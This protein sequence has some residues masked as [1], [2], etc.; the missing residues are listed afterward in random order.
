MNSRTLLFLS[1][2]VN[3]F[4][5]HSAQT[6]PYGL[7]GF[8]PTYRSG[9]DDLIGVRFRFKVTE[10]E[11]QTLR[12]IF[13]FQRLH[14]PGSQ[15][16]YV[17]ETNV[18]SGRVACYPDGGCTTWPL[19][20]TYTEH[21]S[22]LRLAIPDYAFYFR[23]QPGITTGIRSSD[24]VWYPIQTYHIDNIDSLYKSDAISQFNIDSIETLVTMERGDT[25]TDVSMFNR[26]DRPLLSGVYRK[27]TVHVEMPS[28]PIQVCTY[29][30]PDSGARYLT[31]NEA[32]NFASE[33]INGSGFFTVQYWDF[34][35]I[36]ES[37]PVWR[38]DTTFMSNSD[39]DGSG[40]DYG[41]RVVN[42]DGRDRVEFSNR[43]GNNYLPAN[44][45]FSTASWPSTSVD[46]HLS[47]PASP[48][49]D[50]NYPNPVNPSTTIR[51]QIPKG[52]HVSLKVF[53]V[54]GHVVADLVEKDQML[55]HYSVQW[56]PQ[57]STGTYFY[58]IQAPDLVETKRL[59]LIK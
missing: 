43:P 5:A 9:P 49:L 52:G 1:L 59:L 17:I 21:E 41:I 53:D 25:T 42:V 27:W 47:F 37:D 44:T 7:G 15:L 34:A 22:S 48:H 29:V 18:Y 12:I 35:S 54:L 4:C 19:L 2:A 14:N 20:G 51:Y 16:N 55:G 50:Q 8:R 11:S 24:P 36:R 3:V 56:Q 58:R 23:Q 39:Y 30:L 28:R 31:V 45:R 33:F 6:Q 57:L 46:N 26:C 32:M 40:T 13:G 38:V 10:N